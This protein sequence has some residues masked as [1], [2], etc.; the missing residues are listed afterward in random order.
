MTTNT[1]LNDK[2][3]HDQVTPTIKRQKG[4]KEVKMADTHDRELITKKSD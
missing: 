2:N 4:N 1:T 3:N